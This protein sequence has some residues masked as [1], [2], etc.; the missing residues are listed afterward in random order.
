MQR[1]RNKQ[2]RDVLDVE[3]CLF[4]N[5]VYEASARVPS[6][7]LCHPAEADQALA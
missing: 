3:V 2:L 4:G 5:G 1:R 6:Q 7:H